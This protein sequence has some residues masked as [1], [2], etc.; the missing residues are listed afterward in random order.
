VAFHIA[1]SYAIYIPGGGS[2]GTQTAGVLLYTEV[3]AIM[4]GLWM[5]SLTDSN[6][7]TF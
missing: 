1:I 7:Q 2:Q 3:M 4:Y 6:L 5:H